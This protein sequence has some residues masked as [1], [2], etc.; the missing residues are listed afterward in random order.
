MRADIYINVRFKTYA[1]GGRKTS[2]KRKFPLGVDFYACPMIID[3]TAYDCRLLIGDQEL[4][5]GKYYEV[6]VKFLN[7]DLVLPNLFVG[8]NIVLWEGKEVASGTVIK[9]FE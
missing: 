1:E 8:K 4:K 3:G 7:K 9:L 5:L 6:P 2:L